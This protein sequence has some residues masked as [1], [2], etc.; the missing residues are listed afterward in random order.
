MA[1]AALDRLALSLV[2]IFAGATSAHGCREAAQPES[3]KETGLTVFAAASL[4]EVFT[5]LGED[6]KSKHPGVELTFNFAGTQELRTQLEHGAQADVF[7]SADQRHMEELSSTS[8]VFAPVVFAK[9][10]P[11]VAVA[12]DSVETIKSF[13]DLPN[14]E[15]IVIGTEEVPIGRYTVQILDRAAK[16]LGADFRAKVEAK[17]VSRELN[18]KQVLA[19]VTLGEA[20]VGVVYRTDVQTAGAGLGVVAIPAELNVIAEYPIAIVS[21]STHPKLAREWMELVA[22]P[23]GQ[24]ALQKA[25][26]IVPSRGASAP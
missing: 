21:G 2:L 3:A 17:V 18:V 24:A 12:R 1:G 8:R 9:N 10:E 25:G 7:A 11:V 5:A 23:A 22:S 19:K 13:A 14:A 4:R 15:R 16:T 20:Q 26:F 6:F